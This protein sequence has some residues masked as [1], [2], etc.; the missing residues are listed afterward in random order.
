VVIAPGRAKRPGAARGVLEP[1]SAEE[2]ETCPFCAGRE[3]RTPPETLRLPKGSTE[4]SVRVVPNLYPAF[5][6]AEVVVHTPRH[7]R[8]I[9]E[10]EDEELE[11]VAQSWQ[12]RRTAEP[13]GYLL[14]FVNEG[15]DA[16]ASLPHTHSQLVWLGGTPPAV[17]AERGAP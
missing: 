6:R 5:E 2:L 14:A 4:W 15:R 1:P 13:G 17:E 12:Q 9:G 16:G 11:L 8:S 10:L 3:D 7:A